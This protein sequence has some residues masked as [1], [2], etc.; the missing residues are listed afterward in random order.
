VELANAMLYSSFT[1]KPVDLP[2]D[3]AAFET[4]LRKLIDESQFV[5]KKVD[6]VVADMNASFAKV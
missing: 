6:G 1:G 5:K 2:L 4:M 3:G